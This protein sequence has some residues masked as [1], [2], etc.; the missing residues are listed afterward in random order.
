[1]EEVA[2]EGAEVERIQG[3]L[4]GAL[5][6]SGEEVGLGVEVAVGLG[7]IYFYVPVLHLYVPLQGRFSAV[8]LIAPVDLAAILHYQ[9]LCC[10]PSTLCCNELSSFFHVFQGL[11]QF[12]HH[13]LLLPR[14][15][16]LP[17]KAQRE[18]L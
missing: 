6:N 10:S 17:L 2:A 3:T 4:L 12:H 15:F 18:E 11:H 16:Q 8:E 13:L 14:L 7:G 1:M 9:I 5:E